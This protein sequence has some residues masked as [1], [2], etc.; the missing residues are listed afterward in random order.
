MK[1]ADKEII[2][3]LNKLNPVE[4]F[5]HGAKTIATA[6]GAAEVLLADQACN[7]VAIQAK[8]GNTNPVYVGGSGVV[9]TDGYQL[10]ALEAIVLP[11]DNVNRVYLKATT[12][13]EGV[14]FLYG[15]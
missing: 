11:V 6:S 2:S 12:D 1:E 14:N 4:T 13:G 9:A 8:A 3:R 15:I 7:F 5:G 10:A